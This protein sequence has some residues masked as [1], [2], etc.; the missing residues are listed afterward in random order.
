MGRVW[1]SL[2]PLLGALGRLLAVFGTFKIKLFSSIGPRWAA[3][4]LL[5]RFWVDLGKVLKRFWADLEGFGRVLGG[6]WK[7]FKSFE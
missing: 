2:G 6:L 1:G 7:D 4:G 3:K 5:A